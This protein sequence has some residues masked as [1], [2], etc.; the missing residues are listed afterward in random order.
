MNFGAALQEPEAKNEIIEAVT[1]DP[2]NYENVFDRFRAKIEEMKQKALSHEIIDDQTNNDAVE[3]SIQAKKVMNVVES[4]RK[5]KKAPFQAVI[6]VLDSGAKSVKDGMIEV[7]NILDSKI[8][9]YAK[10]REA[11]RLE[12]QRKAEEEARKE[13]ERLESE[14]K[15]EQERLS[16]EA[17]KK[18]EEEGL[19][20]KEAEEAAKRAAESVPKTP[21]IVTSVPKELETKTDAGKAKLVT[22]KEWR[23][24]DISK[25]E[26]AII[27]K[28]MDH[29]KKAI[30]PEINA[31]IKAGIE[32]IPGIEIY[33]TQTLDKRVKR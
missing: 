23:I 33:E 22:K 31:R 11:E 14:R 2:A 21:E 24:T 12:A 17:M 19:A 1:L 30:A 25:I 27:E 6:S 26:K 32:N 7:Q 29:I 4:V 28:R 9:P 8:I 3:M 13:R 10:K 5:E 18:A 16:A 20:Q 15:A